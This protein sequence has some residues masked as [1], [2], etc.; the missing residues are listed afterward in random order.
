[1]AESHPLST[2]AT[3]VCKYGKEQTICSKHASSYH[4]PNERFGGAVEDVPE[5]EGAPA[6]AA[7]AAGV[8]HQDEAGVE[9]QRGGR[10]RELQ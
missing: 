4:S 7:E 10:R 1:M 5:C 2:L 6:G 3:D 9:V 8:A